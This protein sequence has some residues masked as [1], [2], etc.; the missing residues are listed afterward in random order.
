MRVFGRLNHHFRWIVK[1]IVIDFPNHHIN[2]LVKSDANTFF[3]VSIFPNPTAKFL[4]YAYR[5]DEASTVSIAI[6][7]SVGQVVDQ[8]A[9]NVLQES[10]EYKAELDV[11]N[12]P[13]GVY[14][15][16]LQTEME[17]YSK[18]FVVSRN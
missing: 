9:T 5:L 2:N 16:M 4:N 14:H 1:I 8:V 7:N 6:V 18:S 12:W 11:E 13:D 15:F 3:Q 17:T 10:G